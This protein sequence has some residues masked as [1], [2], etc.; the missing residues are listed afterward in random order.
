MET[1]QERDVSWESVSKI[2]LVAILV[3]GFTSLMFELYGFLIPVIITVDA[4][5]MY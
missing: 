3:C 5:I 1:T 4:F 2:I